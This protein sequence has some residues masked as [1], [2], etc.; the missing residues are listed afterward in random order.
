M[1]AECRPNDF[2]PTSLQ[3]L[4]CGCRRPRKKAPVQKGSTTEQ[5]DKNNRRERAHAKLKEREEHKPGAKLTAPAHH[6]RY[7]RPLRGRRLRGLGHSSGDPGCL[8]IGSVCRGLLSPTSTSV[9]LPKIR[10]HYISGHFIGA[11]LIRLH[12]IRFH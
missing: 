9:T 1:P 10:M 12:F 6:R 8:Y 5:N 2:L 4:G 3:V 7:R 11:H